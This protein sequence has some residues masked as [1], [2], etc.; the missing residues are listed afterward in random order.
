MPMAG[1]DMSQRQNGTTAERHNGTTAQKHKTTTDNG[2]TAEQH[3]GR[4]G[5]SPEIVAE[6]V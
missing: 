5:L 6:M 4:S 3:C 1:W 2:T